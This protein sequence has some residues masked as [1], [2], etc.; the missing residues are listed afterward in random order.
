[1]FLFIFSLTLKIYEYILQFYVIFRVIQYRLLHR[2]L[3]IS[4]TQTH[5]CTHR[6][7]QTCTNKHIPTHTYTHKPIYART[8][9][10]NVY[11][12]LKVFKLVSFNKFLQFQLIKNKN[13]EKGRRGSP[14]YST[15]TTFVQQFCHLFGFLKNY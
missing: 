14:L 5:I 9:A 1:M 10:H 8:N 7:T 11:R 15:T 2:L 13:G 6:R 12:K 3:G 4:H